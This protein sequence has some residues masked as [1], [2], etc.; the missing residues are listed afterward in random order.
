M[1]VNRVRR[2]LVQYL[3][4]FVLILAAMGLSNCSGGR[5]SDA[6][7]A[8]DREMVVLLHGLGRSEAAMWLLAS[9]I[10]AAGFDVV[11]IGYDSLGDSPERILATVSREID[12]CCKAAQKPVHFVGHSLGGLIIRAY[13]ATND[14]H[15]LGRV[16]LIATLMPARRWST[17]IAI[18]GG[19]TS[20]APPRSGSARIPTVSPTRYRRRIIRSGSSR[21]FGKPGLST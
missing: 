14:V 18:H 17:P 9:R 5:T 13:L 20:P 6:R 1:S 15:S 4:A 2:L 19:S 11:R 7:H 12:A 3:A 10:E 16:V 21:A 8:S